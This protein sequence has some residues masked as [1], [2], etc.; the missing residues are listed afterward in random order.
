MP[1]LGTKHLAI[2]PKLASWANLHPD[3]Q[4]YLT[5]YNPEPALDNHDTHVSRENLQ[6][7]LIILP[8]QVLPKK[9][10]CQR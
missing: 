8:G 3:A 10:D 5:T 9:C 7:D 1:A 6:W 2:V 4:S